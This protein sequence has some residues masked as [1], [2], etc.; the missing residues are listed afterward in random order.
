MRNGSTYWMSMIAGLLGR[1]IS[2]L[3]M[4]SKLFM[5]VKNLRL[6]AWSFKAFSNNH[7]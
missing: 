1:S 6:S 2:P 3:S 7:H 4:Y 5:L